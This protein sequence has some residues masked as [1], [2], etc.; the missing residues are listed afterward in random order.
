MFSSQLGADADSIRSGTSPGQNL[1]LPRL[2]LQKCGTSARICWPRVGQANRSILR[3][4]SCLGN[5]PAI[6]SS[7][8]DLGILLPI[9]QEV[10]YFARRGLFRYEGKLAY[11]SARAERAKIAGYPER[12]AQEALGHNNKAVHRAYARKAKVELPSLGEYERQRAK[13]TVVS[14]PIEASALAIA[15]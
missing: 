13:F 7:S 10:F 11:L 8:V 4:M 12:F 1:T 2:A 15:L 6:D 5:T 14:K 3:Q 9:G